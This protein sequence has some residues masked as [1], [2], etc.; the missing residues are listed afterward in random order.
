MSKRDGPRDSDPTVGELLK[1]RY[2]FYCAACC[3]PAR[4]EA[5]KCG[6]CGGPLAD[7]RSGRLVGAGPREPYREVLPEDLLSKGGGPKRA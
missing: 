4:E 1:A 2:K 3:K 7:L 6:W 5:P